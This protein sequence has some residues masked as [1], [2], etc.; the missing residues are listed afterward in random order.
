MNQTITI[1]V[2]IAGAVLAALAATFGMAGA[3]HV[4]SRRAQGYFHL[5]FYAIILTVVIATVLGN[6]DLAVL[7]SNLAE[8]PAT[9]RHP[10]LTI[11]QPLLSLLILTVAGE[12]ILTHWLRRDKTVRTPYFLLSMFVLFWL[13]TVAAPALL[14]AHPQFSHEFV[15]PAV[16]VA[17]A[18]LA[19]GV[20]R[21]RAI[22]AVRNALFL[23]MLG[24]LLLVFIEPSKVLDAGYSY[25]FLP[26]VPRF[27]GVVSLIPIP[28][29]A[30]E[31]S[32]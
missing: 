15:Y 8:S 22:A 30:A 29:G 26:G 10:L 14:G 2:L 11:A 31:S 25:G 12:R 18:V 7:A 4:T 28:M 32:C 3:V 19:S 6:R 27:A 5:V 23:F 1:F 24:G 16:I 20:E 17:A 21:D 13:G 9:P